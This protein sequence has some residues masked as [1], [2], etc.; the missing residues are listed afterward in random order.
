MDDVIYTGQ[1]NE[2]TALVLEIFQERDAVMI[3]EQIPTQEIEELPYHDGLKAAQL[4]TSVFFESWPVGR[5]CDAKKELIW[6]RQ[7][8]GKTFRVVYS[9]ADME[10]PDAL[11]PVTEAEEWRKSEPQPYLLWGS[12]LAA[13]NPDAAETTF[14]EARIPRLLTYPVRCQDE[15]TRVQATVIHYNDSDDVM[16]HYRFCTIEPV[17]QDEGGNL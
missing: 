7:E 4:D 2:L 3:L 6:T 13:E 12:S 16:Q 9:G 10:L 14:A 11:Q 1:V 17:L 15:K 5:V 8:D